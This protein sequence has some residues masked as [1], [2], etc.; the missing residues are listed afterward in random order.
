MSETPHHRNPSPEIPFPEATLDYPSLPRDK[1][2]VRMLLDDRERSSGLLEELNRLPRVS[3]EVVRLDV[4]D[5]VVAGAAVVERKTVFDLA[6]SLVDGRL[7]RQANRLATS[8]H[9]PLLILEG[10]EELLDGQGVPREALQ[11]A[12][13]TLNLLYAIPVV[14]S[15]DVAETARLLYYIGCQWQRLRQG[16]SNIRPKRAVKRIST[17]Q[18]RL[19]QALPGIGTDRAKRLLRQFG[20]VRA[21]LQADEAA[22]CS[23]EGIG[24]ATANRITQLLDA[25]K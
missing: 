12:L 19:L 1:P 16:E 22:L 21:V 24:P 8:P 11:G 15:K 6:Q 4:G 25:R 20:T 5:V 7:F 2:P 13:L 9:R 23:V 18:L 17:Q 10:A 14:R 3:V